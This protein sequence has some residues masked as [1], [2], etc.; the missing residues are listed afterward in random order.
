MVW[1][2]GTPS[3][4]PQ[5]LRKQIFERDGYQCQ[6]GY[7]DICVGTPSH[8][9]H[10]KNLASL[11]LPRGQNDPDNLQSA[12]LPCSRRKTAYEGLAA[13]GRLKTKRVIPNAAGFIPGQSDRTDPIMQAA[14]ARAAKAKAEASERA[15]LRNEELKRLVAE[16]NANDD[17]ES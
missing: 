5:K 14:E 4:I 8:V 16:W 7:P 10:I 15:R 13:Q 1:K 12:C 2:G 3:G 11:G 6:I 9:D 17:D